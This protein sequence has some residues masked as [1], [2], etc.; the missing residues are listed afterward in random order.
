MLAGLR[1]LK[2]ELEAE[3]SSPQDQSA[4]PS[5]SSAKSNVTSEACYSPLAAGGLGGRGV[6]PTLFSSSLRRHHQMKNRSP[7]LPF[8]NRSE[9]K[10]NAY[11]AD[12]RPG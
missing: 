1:I 8:E 4:L 2:G 6:L 7:F 11:F 12:G 10:S 3:G 9:D 5:L